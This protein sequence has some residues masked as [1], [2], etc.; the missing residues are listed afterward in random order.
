MKQFKDKNGKTLKAGDV[1][2]IDGTIKDLLYSYE[3]DEGKQNLGFNA[4]N[5]DWYDKYGCGFVKYYSL[6]YFTIEDDVLVDFE[7][8][9]NI[10]DNKEDIKLLPERCLRMARYI[11][12]DKLGE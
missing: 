2:L 6:Y 3:N 7:I 9:G 12:G 5:P 11:L 4:T 8:I 10:F 1:V